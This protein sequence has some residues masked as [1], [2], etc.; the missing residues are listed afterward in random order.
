M[1]DRRGNVAMMFGLL[2]IAMLSTAGMAID[3]QRSA[4]I[5]ADLQESADAAL[6]AAIRLRTSRPEL[7]NDEIKA[8]ARE[9]FEG[10]TRSDGRFSFENFDL[11]FNPAEDAFTL[12]FDA[13][14]DT[15]LL[16]AVG[17]NHFKPTIRS[18][19]AL[20]KPP[21]MEVVMVLDNTG[22][23][24]DDGK[25]DD[26]K[27]AAHNLIATL[28]AHPDADV[29]IGLVPFA[30][31]VSVGDDQE[32]ASW[33]DG[34]SGGGFDGCVGSRAYPAN[35]TDG[36]YA[37]DPVPEVAGEACP[38]DI[39]PLT[40]SRSVI[41]D[42]IDDMDGDG[43]TYIPAG[44]AWGWRVISAAAPFTEGVTDSELEDRDGRKTI[45]L[46]TDGENTKSP[47]Y[48]THNAENIVDANRIT[49]ELCEAIK[50]EDIVI[51][52]IAFA[53]SD[54]TVKQLL[55]DCGTTPGHFF[56][57]ETA[58]ELNTTFAAIAGELRS[59]ALTR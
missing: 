53:V 38:D 13:M 30:Q 16:R 46:M 42:A 25:L 9:F 26:L 44:L 47:D 1:R 2:L 4:E 31:Y 29:K 12:T 40:A 24:N 28:Y 56:E 5:R 21:Y 19:A 20:G 37:V 59:I 55:E 45:I 11:A 32:G 10:N 33:L 36:G 3:F 43:W 50:D 49:E 57:P 7:S 58:D 48:P 17:F 27:E 18:E 35:T 39:Q 41:E 51:Y 52:A 23:M 6:I 22:S 14:I 15:T 54:I 34:A 8:R